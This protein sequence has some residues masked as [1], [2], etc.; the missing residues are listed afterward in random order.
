MTRSVRPDLYPDLR[1]RGILHM[2]MLLLRRIKVLFYLTLALLLIAVI[3]T[4]VP[5]GT[6]LLLCAAIAAP[7]FASALLVAGD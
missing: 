6:W 2:L 5:L 1:P 7:T 3:G 4:F